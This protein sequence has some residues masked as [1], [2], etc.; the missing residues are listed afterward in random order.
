MK[1]MMIGVMVALSAVLTQAESKFRAPSYEPNVLQR[2]G[3]ALLRIVGS[4]LSFFTEGAQSYNE[5][6]EATGSANPFS[7]IGGFVVCGP[8]VTC[9]EAVGGI[10]ELVTFQ[11]FKS[12]AYPWEVDANDQEMVK[13]I[14]E[15]EEEERLARETTPKS[16]FVGELI[17]AA[18]GAAAGAAVESAF[19]HHGRGS[20]QTVS[21]GGSSGGSP[22]G[23]RKIRHSSCNG[24]GQCNVCHGKGYLGSDPTNARLKCRSCGG[25]GRCCACNGGY[26]YVN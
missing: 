24:T 10:C 15:R 2:E 25:S 19:G 1:K 8:F 22:R 21:C 20:V 5:H 14:R 4:P 18:A 17:G 9:F 11:Q 26:V 3:L 13:Y 6:R 7:F 23:S 16:D 12:F